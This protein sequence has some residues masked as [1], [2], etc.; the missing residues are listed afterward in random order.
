VHDSASLSSSTSNKN[1]RVLTASDW[2]LKEVE[3]S[4]RGKSFDVV[5]EGSLSFPLTLQRFLEREFPGMSRDL[6]SKA[7]LPTVRKFLS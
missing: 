6:F 4:V 3:G 7:D 5:G 2:F 1:S